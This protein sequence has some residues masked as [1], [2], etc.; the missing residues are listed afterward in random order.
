MLVSS[1]EPTLRSLGFALK[2]G[3]DGNGDTILLESSSRSD[4]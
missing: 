4:A 3:R 1:D 2:H